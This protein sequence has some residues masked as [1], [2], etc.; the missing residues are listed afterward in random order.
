MEIFQLAEK[1]TGGDVDTL[2]EAMVD[3][4]IDPLQ[5][6]LGDEDTAKIDAHFQR[7]AL[8]EPVT[9]PK[10]PPTDDQVLA[11]AES[12]GVDLDAVMQAAERLGELEALVLWVESYQE[13]VHDQRIKDNAKQ[14]FEIDRLE[15]KEQELASRLSAA[16]NRPSPN[17]QEIYDRLGIKTPQTVTELATWDGT[18]DGE[19]EPDFLRNARSALK[20]LRGVV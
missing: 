6:S 14:Q 3:L 5:D 11:L 12:A 19:S 13:L 2:K 16:V 20:T 7:L 18:P 10:A 8:P 4:E 9:T 17:F 15:G 1:Y